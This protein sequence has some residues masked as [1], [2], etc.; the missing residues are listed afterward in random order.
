[1]NEKPDA[2][3]LTGEEPHSKVDFHERQKKHVHWL[4]TWLFPAIF[5]INLIP[6][7]VIIFMGLFV[8]DRSEDIVNLSLV[9]LLVGCALLFLVS[10]HQEIYMAFY[11]LW[12]HKVKSGLSLLLGLFFL[13]LLPIFFFFFLLW[14]EL[15][16]DLPGEWNP[17]DKLGLLV[18]RVTFYLMLGT[19]GFILVWELYREAKKVLKLRIYPRVLASAE[20]ETN[21]FLDGY[22]P[23]PVELEFGERSREEL[24]KFAGFL[25]RYELLSFVR[26]EEDSLVLFFPE[27]SDRKSSLKLRKPVGPGWRLLPL[28]DWGAALGFM[29]YFKLDPSYMRVHFTGKAEIFITPGDYDFLEVPVSYHLFCEKLA[30]CLQKAY[31]LFEKG[32]ERSALGMFKI[33]TKK[34]SL[35]KGTEKE[36]ETCE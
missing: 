3:K 18:M 6:P 28:G 19:L 35:V 25:L 30:D 20:Q 15:W 29:S 21:E 13:V 32:D 31:R 1:M 12:V 8:G 4:W 33:E 10:S 36:V 9:L 5:A 27:S 24:L 26:E 16:V 2:P 7:L 34:R 11:N 22:S 23:R 14:E 17:W